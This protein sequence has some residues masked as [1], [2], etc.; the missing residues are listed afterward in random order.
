M[1]SQRGDALSLVNKSST[2]KSIKTGG[3]SSDD[4][5]YYIYLHKD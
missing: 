1:S 3:G 5:N 2:S 4:G